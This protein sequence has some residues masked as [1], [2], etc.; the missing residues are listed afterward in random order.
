MISAVIITLNEAQNIAR[1]LNSL[2]GVADEIIVV[3]SGS[4]DETAEICAQLG[5][6]VVTR[7][8]EGYAKT[9]NY[10]NSLAR[11]PFI[12][13]LDA[14]EALSEELRHSILAVKS[15]LLGAYRFSRLTYY[16]GQP[17]KHGG[18]YPDE[19]IRLFPKDAAR[20][21]GDF[22]HENLA[23]SEGQ[24]ITKL[25]GDLLHYS[26]HE[27]VDHQKRLV[28]Y[29]RLAA[30]KM[31]AQGKPPAIF[32][33]WFGP[34]WRWFKM[35]ILKSGWLDG[36]AGW[37]IAKGSAR[38]MWL[39]QIYLRKR[40]LVGAKPFHAH[41][42]VLMVNLSKSWG[43][44]EKWFFTVGKA[45]RE[46]GF[47]V[48]WYCYSASVLAQR[49][50]EE[51][52]PYYSARLRFLKLLLPGQLRLVKKHLR[53]FLPDTVLL[54]ASHEL[55]TVGWLAKRVGIEKVVF[56]RGVSYPLSDNRLN[57]WFIRNVPTHFLANSQAT[58]E[59][60]SAVFPFVE[61]LSHL[62]LNNGIDPSPWVANDKGRIP[63][64][65][66]MSARLS[67]EKGIDRAIE[68]LA[69]LRDRGQQFE[70]HILGE[71]PARAE[72]EAKIEQ[73][74]LTNQIILRGFVTDVAAELNRCSF[75]LF[76]PRFGEGTSLALIEAM[77]LELACVVMD[78]PAMAE[79]VEHG[80]TGY[81]VPDGDIAAL[82]ECIGSLLSDQDLRLKMGKSGRQRALEHFTLERLVSDLA[83]W[84]KA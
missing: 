31:Y 57:Q 42:R 46:H 69:I 2:E 19:K 80:T 7:A 84:L 61:R 24:K 29:A 1:C 65:I 4:T 70:L 53:D 54:N 13:S 76:T 48:A 52:L 50:E 3:D 10:G 38:A 11:F 39:R 81:V 58:F 55:K 12:L 16:C 45:L 18:W 71:G 83:D 47:E 22:V 15:N 14:D 20:W 62:T 21:E 75:F 82:A 37:Q 72:I 66:G 28:R 17:I 59:A 9:K 73:H 44:G 51:G 56:R 41:Q 40:Y 26:F 32:K 6:N 35:Y 79:V 43:G 23:L 49:L 5:A 36:K 78:S 74:D 60:F 68:A 25:A 8:W 67:P 64:R 33:Q 77:L 63:N 30:D 34:F 27:P